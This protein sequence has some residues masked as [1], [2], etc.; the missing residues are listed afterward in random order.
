[1]RIA[2]LTTDSREHY[3]EYANP[4]PHFGTAPAALLQGL[5]GV[6]ELEVHVISCAREP[7]QSPAKLADNIFFHSLPVGKLGWMRTLYAG[8]IRATRRKLREIN[9]DLVHGQGTERDC[10]MAAVLSGFPNVLTLHGIMAEMATVLNARP[11]SFYWLARALENFALRRTGGV[12]CNSSH[13]ETNVQPRT[14]R[15]WRVPNAVRAE[16][17]TPAVAPQP[18]RRPLLLNVGVIAEYKRQVELL[19]VAHA[20]HEQGLNFELKFLGQLSEKSAY[21][22]AFRDRVTAAEKNGYT[23]YEGFKDLAELI[24]L[25][26]R[27]AAMI[28]VPT[29][30]SFGLVAAEALARNVKLFGSRVGGL[31]DIAAG[32]EGAE[33]F[34]E[35]DW[36][37]LQ[38]AIAS[39]LRAGATRPT[40][41]AQVMRERYQ[42]EVIARRHLEIY[43]EVLKR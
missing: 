12:F 3:R 1:M 9:P 38:G 42:P 26:D 22:R 41:A 20:L 31:V 43:R 2:L 33:L 23:S 28:H 6:R 10:A 5:A 35:N 13:T 36:A 27:A 16:F 40:Q 30:E 17:F 21:G 15:V 19:D 34:A 14:G 11:G 25:Y 4:S 32:V 7:M 37:G 39:W 8:C 24:P 29:A 18:A